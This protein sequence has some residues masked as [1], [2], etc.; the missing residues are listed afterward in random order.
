MV[1]LIPKR[2][3]SYPACCGHWDHSAA[4]VL[5]VCSSAPHLQCSPGQ[6]SWRVWLHGPRPRA[7]CPSL[8]NR[9][10][11]SGTSCCYGSLGKGAPVECRTFPSGA[12]S[13]HSPLWCRAVHS[14]VR[15]SASSFPGRQLHFKHFG[16]GT[17][18][19]LQVAKSCSQ[20]SRRK[21]LIKV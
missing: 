15:N 1:L 13:L 3:H 20:R 21:P 8:G 16:P 9:N 7:S 4:M 2:A 12:L 19:D 18:G 17:F 5:R 11:Q 6:G 10:S 14:S